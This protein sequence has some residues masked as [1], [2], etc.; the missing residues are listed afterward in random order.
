MRTLHD[1]SFE[2]KSEVD[3][4]NSEASIPFDYSTFTED[5]N[6]P[7]MQDLKPDISKQEDVWSNLGDEKGVDSQELLLSAMCFKN[8]RCGKGESKFSHGKAESSNF[9]KFDDTLT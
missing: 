4:T 8:A 9:S 6:D 3:S 5:S 7:F 1:D 2:L